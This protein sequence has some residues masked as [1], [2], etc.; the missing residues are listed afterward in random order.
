MSNLNT[1]FEED[2]GAL[3]VK[4]EDLSSV[5]ALAKRAK[6]LEKEIEEFESVLKER[7][8]QLRKLQEESIPNMLAEL[9]MKD[10]TMAD[11]SKIT[12]KPF[13]S[14]S[15]K[16][17]NRAQA[18]E[19]LREH[20]YDDIIKNTVSVR[21]GRGEDQLC[22]TLLNLLREQNYPVEQ[23][24]K[25]EPQTLKAWVREQ[26]ERGTAFPSELFGVYIGQKATIK[27]A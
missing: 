4:D 7:Q 13:Y 25:I 24:Q 10:F 23:A 26:T 8:E 21:F 16:E 11:G 22:D 14:A 15:I 1:M 12:V 2:A 3:T 19:W 9:G 27:S 20:G 17:E 5:A 18:Y 6:M